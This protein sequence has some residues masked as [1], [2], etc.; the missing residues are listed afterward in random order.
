MRAK[1]PRVMGLD[2]KVSGL[3][4]VRQVLLPLGEVSCNP[5]PYVNEKHSGYILTVEGETAPIFLFPSA[6]KTAS[7]PSGARV[8]V[9]KYDKIEAAELDLSGGHWW[10]HPLLLDALTKPAVAASAARA[11]WRGAFKFVEEDLD[12]GVAGLRRPQVGAL[13]AIHA[14]WSTS[15]ETATIVL[16]TGIGKTETMLSTLISAGCT[17]VLVVVPTDALRT[18][19][20]G[21][22]E[23][24]GMLKAPAI[25]VLAASAQCPVVGTLVSKPKT[26]EDV[27]MFFRQ[28]NVVVTSSQ[29]AGGC[30]DEV[31][32][33]MAELCSHLFIDEAHHAEANTWKKLREKFEG[34]RVLQ[35]TATPFREDGEKVGGKLIYT[36]PLKKAQEEGYFRPIRFREVY[37][38]DAREGDMAIA[39]A[40]LDELD[41]DSSGKHIAMAR[42][43]SVE[44][45][46]HILALYQSLNRYRAVAIH[47]KLRVR[48]RE[49]AVASILSGVA[50]VVVCVDMLGE[51][52][53]LPELKIA[54]FH[55]IRKSLAVTLQ[56]AGRFTRTRTDLGDPVFI[57]NTA[58]IDVREEL[59]KLYSQDPDWNV[60]L[61]EMSAAAINQELS[62]QEFFRGFEAFP[63]ELPLKD[64]R[65]A[66]SMVVY[67][68]HC[69]NWAP[70]GY[71]KGFRGLS[72]GDKL[73]HTINEH[74]KT[75]VVV[76]ATEQ[77]VR[78]SDVES[79][80]EW[81]WELFVAVWDKERRLLY[82]HGSNISGSYKDLAKAICGDDV[83][84]VTAPNVY[85]CFH[86]VKRL[87]LNNVGLDEHLGRKV[88][89]TGRMGSDVESRIGSAARRGAFRAVLAGKGYE[90]GH[91][92]SVG[93][94]KRGR[95][96]SSQRLRIDTFARWSRGIGAKLVDEAI[97]ADQILAGT[98]KPEAVG[99]VPPKVAIAADWPSE[100]LDLAESRTNFGPSGRDEEPLTYVDIDVASRD[101]SAPI[102]LRVFGANWE[103]LL[104]L[105]LFESNDGFDFRFKHVGGSTVSVRS[106]G[107]SLS[108][109]EFFSEYPPI[110]WFA[111]GSSL[112]GCD[113]VELPSDTLMPYPSEKLLPLDWTDIDIQRESQ[114]EQRNPNTIQHRVITQLKLDS[115]YN[116]I[117]DDDGA[118]EAA[119]IVA[120]RLTETGERQRVNVEFYHCKFSGAP[121][122]GSRVD[123][124]YVVCGQAQRS[125]RWLASHESRTEL[126][127][128]L[129]HREAKRQLRATRFERGDLRALG[130][131]RDMSR[132]CEVALKIYV[133]QPGLSKKDASTSQLALLAVTERYLTDT[134]EVPFDVLCSA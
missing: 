126:F 18:Q 36:Y 7:F 123:D 8:L 48:E 128:H 11:S 70:R 1:L 47:S 111:D 17:R 69:A 102:V 28:C 10:L 3:G 39:S 77:G 73:Y 127:N 31:Q 58:L 93:A 95:V 72:Q 132:R 15:D 55:D 104:S 63:R 134:Y 57:A 108:L 27:D 115:T 78:W 113:Y 114:G 121:N 45:A 2:T 35:F 22:F 96:W 51:G 59:Q 81:I 50:R 67:K 75:L 103:S 30:T 66:A 44:R 25:N 23:S 65:P 20:S 29:L 54:A 49:E 110:I 40:A 68:T 19:L 12:A 84:L 53:D 52:F 6:P 109:V 122:P 90:H 83:Q 74:E 82:L 119:D 76:A 80:R 79:V 60:L 42:V 38:F 133:V 92:A 98:L 120:I 106:G 124:L 112:E 118:G 85:R 94:A 43:N 37:E 116:I 56:L 130:N 62:S 89:Y 46:N 117:F 33:R 91:K 21:K 32:V 5:V 87:V 125:V 41:A 71:R 61:P 13:H 86:G 129:L 14:H 9:A 99:D 24:L 97:D 26:H 34:K 64:L 100:V 16:P 131:I 107:S 105:E 4:F 101:V 88:R